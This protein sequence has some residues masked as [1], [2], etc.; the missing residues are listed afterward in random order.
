MFLLLAAE[1]AAL[2]WVF[3]PVSIVAYRSTIVNIS[4]LQKQ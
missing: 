4:S 2:L 3:F 1:L